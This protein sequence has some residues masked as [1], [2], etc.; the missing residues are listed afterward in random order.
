MEGSH[1][2]WAAAVLPPGPQC[3]TAGK[4]GGIFGLEAVT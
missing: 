2:L 4:G 3:C 1:P